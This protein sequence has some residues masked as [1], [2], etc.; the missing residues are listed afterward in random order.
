[1]IVLGFTLDWIQKTPVE[2]DQ[3]LTR[4]NHNGT[5]TDVTPLTPVLPDDQI[6]DS[7]TTVPTIEPS[8]ETSAKLDELTP[9]TEPTIEPSE[10]TS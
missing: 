3:S 9:T 1:M 2:V 10:D 4:Q 5:T 6:V 7:E 8:E